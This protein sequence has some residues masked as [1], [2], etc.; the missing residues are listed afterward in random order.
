MCVGWGG[1]GGGGGGDLG[2]AVKAK[3]SNSVILHHF[4]DCP[5]NIPLTYFALVDTRRCCDY[6]ENS[7][8]RK[9]FELVFTSGR[10]L[11][12]RAKFT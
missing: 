9:T 4:V 6:N 1:G 11:F 3:T 7:K 8:C 2:V 5:I 10:E 12:L